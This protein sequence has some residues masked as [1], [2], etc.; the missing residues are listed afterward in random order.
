MS[1]LQ[2]AKSSVPPAMSSSVFRRSRGRRLSITRSPAKPGLR[3]FLPA[4]CNLR[5]MSVSDPSRRRRT[6]RPNHNRRAFHAPTVHVG[7]PSRLPVRGAS[8]P[9]AQ[10]CDRAAG[11]RPHRQARKPTLRGPPEQLLHAWAA[12]MSWVRGRAFRWRAPRAVR[13]VPGKAARVQE[14]LCCHH[15]SQ[16]PRGIRSIR[17]ARCRG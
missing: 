17:E 10:T 16:K 13:G 6:H 14:F 2:G 5:R 12:S 15:E 8:S 4:T 7:Q 11:S 1:G 3:S 9:A